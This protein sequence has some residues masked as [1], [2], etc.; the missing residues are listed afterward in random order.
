MTASM[1]DLSRSDEGREVPA[2]LALGKDVG[3]D[4]RR[5]AFQSLLRKEIVEKDQNGYRLSV[6]MLGFWILRNG[7]ASGYLEK[8][9][10]SPLAVLIQKSGLIT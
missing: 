8:T 10:S 6:K 4:R 7:A 3:Q 5:S 1:D 9:R 2:E